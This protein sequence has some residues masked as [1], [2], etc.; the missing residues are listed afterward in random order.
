MSNQAVDSFALLDIPELD[1]GII[2][3]GGY[4]ATIG[5]DCHTCDNIGV[6][7]EAVFNPSAFD[8]PDQHGI[9]YAGG[10]QVFVGNKFHDTDPRSICIFDQHALYIHR[11]LYTPSFSLY[12]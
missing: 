6:S 12:Q 5:A 4:Q 10:Y 2:I 7:F 8:I 11:H 9:P 1:G 3:F